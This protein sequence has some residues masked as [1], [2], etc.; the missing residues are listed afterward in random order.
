MAS[1]A[2]TRLARSDLPARRDGAEPAPPGPYHHGVL[3][4]I[5]WAVLQLPRPRLGRG[6]NRA[7]FLAYHHQAVQRARLRYGI[8]PGTGRRP[9]L[10]HLHRRLGEQQLA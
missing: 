8:L 10:G 6:A 7:V 5:W 2:V 9:L 4:N 1:V 3:A